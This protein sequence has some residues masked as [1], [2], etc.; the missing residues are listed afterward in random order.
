[1]NC[2]YYYYLEL[3]LSSYFNIVK[4]TIMDMVPKGIMLHLVN[5]SRE[6]MQKALLSDL[7]KPDQLEELLRE[8]DH[9]VKRR[10]EIKKM[11]EALYRA[12]VIVSTV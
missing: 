1:M 12:D 3:L 10:K 7:Y 5:P 2:C 8:P 4:K 11:I 9:I 6:G